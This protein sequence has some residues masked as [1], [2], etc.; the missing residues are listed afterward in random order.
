MASNN[1]DDHGVVLRLMDELSPL[2]VP[3][4]KGEGE[5]QE[6]EIKNGYQGQK[7]DGTNTSDD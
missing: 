1:D 3:R 5:G 2:N 6:T 7:E 4:G